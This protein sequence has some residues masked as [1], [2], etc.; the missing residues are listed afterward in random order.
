VICA[1]FTTLSQSAVNSRYEVTVSEWEIDDIL[2]EALDH[3]A[4]CNVKLRAVDEVKRSDIE[5]V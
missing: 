1:V 2:S 4:R 5:N 3:N